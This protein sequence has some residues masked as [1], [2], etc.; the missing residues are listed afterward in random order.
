VAKTRMKWEKA[1]I[2]SLIAVLF[3]TS[4]YS[5]TP[6]LPVTKEEA[7]E[8]S[9][10]S[11]LVREGLAIARSLTIETRYYNTSRLEELK[12]WHSDPIFKNVPKS[13]F[14]E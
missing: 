4:I 5:L 8:V 2:L 12:K 9:K 3:L 1:K 7:I 10:T 14:W 6:S 11:E 13:A